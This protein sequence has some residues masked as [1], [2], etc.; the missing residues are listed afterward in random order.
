MEQPIRHETGRKWVY[1]LLVARVLYFNCDEGELTI[2]EV[3]VDN[4]LVTAYRQTKVEEF[5][6]SMSVL[7]IKD[8][9]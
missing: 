9:G 5:F 6:D 3:Y 1:S 2:V 8:L 7:F 4:F